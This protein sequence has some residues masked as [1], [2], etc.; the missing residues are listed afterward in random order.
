ME[1]LDATPSKRNWLRN[2]LIVLLKTIT[3]LVVVGLGM[4]AGMGLVTSLTPDTTLATM[5]QTDLFDWKMLNIQYLGLSIG[6]VLST[7]LYRYFVDDKPYRSLGL[8]IDRLSKETLVGIVWAVGILTASFVIVWAMNGVEIVQTEKLGLGLWGYLSWFFLVAIVEEFVFRGY[9]LQMMTEHLNYTIAII[10]TSIGFA[11]I[12]LGNAHFTWIAFC[13]LT[14]GGVFMAL[15]YLKYQSLYAPIGFHWLW[16]YFQGNILGFGVSGNDVL[17][18]L[19]ISVEGP[20]WLSG[21]QFGL[22]GSIFT[23]ILL[24]IASIY[25]WS[26]S[27]QQ[28]EAIAWKEEVGPAIA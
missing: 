16:N 18:V 19:Q 15:L 25:L 5:A 7:L 6:V 24:G 9:L 2:S 10:L 17:G 21:G 1:P 23:C 13:N 3:Y 22:E 8:G 4:Y 28:L 27:R 26:S 11:I 12:H 20:H 14:L